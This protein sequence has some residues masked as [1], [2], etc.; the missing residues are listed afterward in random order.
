MTEQSAELDKFEEEIRAWVRREN[1]SA[2]KRLAGKNGSQMTDELGKFTKRQDGPY[3]KAAYFEN[4]KRAEL[5]DLIRS[6]HGHFMRQ[7]DASR[8][9]QLA[10]REAQIRALD[11]EIAARPRHWSTL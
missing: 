9:Q 8:E 2:A 7:M 3:K 1:R 6:A 11:A 10:E 4:P 5:Y